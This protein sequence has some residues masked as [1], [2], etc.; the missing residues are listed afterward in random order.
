VRFLTFDHMAQVFEVGVD[1]AEVDFAD[2]AEVD[3]ADADLA[4][5]PPSVLIRELPGVTITYFRASAPIWEGQ[6]GFQLLL[7][8]NI[9]RDQLWGGEGVKEN[10]AEDRGGKVGGLAES[11]QPIGGEKEP[12]L[13]GSPLQV[14]AGLGDAFRWLLGG[15]NRIQSAQNRNAPAGSGSTQAALGTGSPAPSTSA[16][17][18]GG[19]LG[20]ATLTSGGTPKLRV[21]IH[22]RNQNVNPPCP[23]PP[24]HQTAQIAITADFEISG[25][26]DSDTAAA[27]RVKL[28][29]ESTPGSFRND[30]KVCGYFQEQVD[31]VFGP[32]SEPALAVPPT[33]TSSF[34]SNF[35]LRKDEM[36]EVSYE[37]SRA[38]EGTWTGRCAFTKVIT[39]GSDYANKRTTG[40]KI[41]PKLRLLDNFTIESISFQHRVGSRGCLSFVHNVHAYEEGVVVLHQSGRSLRAAG[42]TYESRIEGLWGLEGDDFESFSISVQQDL[43]REVARKFF[44][45]RY[46]KKEPQASCQNVCKK[47]FKV[48]QNV[49]SLL[50]GTRDIRY[51]NIAEGEQTYPNL[52]QWLP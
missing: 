25:L 35:N 3:F 51:R 9:G 43:V 14:V 13:A 20:G 29:T 36:E 41:G 52:F 27:V 18:S 6:A 26:A 21:R 45:R 42:G 44:G 16:A 24:H 46:G 19:G 17:A 7:A 49:R 22:F 11:G 30:S 1:A 31:I 38:R 39:C 4:E 10:A 2:A 28:T 47:E 8:V 48:W 33:Q 50:V 34:Q 32:S 12:L 5:S 37:F 15:S 23:S 40:T